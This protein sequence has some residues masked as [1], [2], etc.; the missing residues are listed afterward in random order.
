MVD[1]RVITGSGPPNRKGTAGTRPAETGT[2]SGL[3]GVS[4]LVVGAVTGVTDIVEAMHF[5]IARLSP[6][7]GVVQ[8]GRTRG[9]TGLVYRSVRGITSAVGFGLDATLAQVEPLVRQSRLTSPRR[10]AL[11]AVLNGVLGD[12]LES[13]NNPLAIPM[14][15]RQRGEPL[16]LDRQTLAE[17]AIPVNGRILVLVHGLCMNDLGWQRQGHDHGTM[18]ARDL[19]Y[20]DVH[21]RY[22]SGRS[23]AANGREFA[24]VM[25]RLV[26][27]WPVPVSELAIVGHSM[28]GLVAR[29]AYHY[30][31]LAG[32]QWTEHLDKLLFVGTPH[33]G[34]P[35]ERAGNGLQTILGVS[36][37]T[38]P[39][40]GIGRIRSAGVV[41]LRY[42]TI[43]D[44][45]DAAGSHRAPAVPLPEAVQC[46][47]IAA[48]TRPSADVPGWRLPG[49]GLVLV[50]S[51]LGVHRDPSR[52]LNIPDSRQRIVYGLGHLDL[53]SSRE[54][55][56]QLHAWLVQD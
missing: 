11:V 43:V 38:A 41:N 34:A 4:Q 17:S 1:R 33:H 16:H 39:L 45:D 40:T 28:G 51:A 52:C 9:V 50:D 44:D 5:N 12:H 35:L 29:S 7:V 42:G 23:I 26:R 14:H 6:I 2:V 24:D 55:Y 21:L 22:N 25:E 48:T 8:T 32:H 56:D 19:G 18:L 46:F 36:P 31:R 13:S 37:Y 49:D 47:A 30:A 3:R 20:T 27:E 15:L 54:V 10:E 53:L